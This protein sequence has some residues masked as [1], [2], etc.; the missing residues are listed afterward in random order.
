MAS[1]KVQQVLDEV[2][3]MMAEDN[4]DSSVKNGLENLV[5]K[6]LSLNT[7]LNAIK[8]NLDAILKDKK[9][10]S[11]D[12]PKMILLSMQVNRMLPRLLGLSKPL[13][14][15]QVKY[16]IYGTVYFY[17]ADKQDEFF[18]DGMTVELFR[19]FFSAAWELVEFDPKELIGAVK[20][21]CASCCGGDDVKAN[22]PLP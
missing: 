8:G 5:K 6:T 21:M 22:E 20:G 13:S 10:D 2:R 17:I 14:S 18:T 4:V 1:Q 15:L 7:Y 9:V 16:V 3:L 12:V 19:S 11:K